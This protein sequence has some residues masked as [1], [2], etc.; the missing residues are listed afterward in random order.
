MEK[1]FSCEFNEISKKTF[2]TEHLQ[3]TVFV[4]ILIISYGTKFRPH[5]CNQ[6]FL[7]RK[8]FNISVHIQL[9]AGLKA[10][11]RKKQYFSK[12]RY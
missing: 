6:P 7:L 4:R 12:Y 11:S 1:V 8:A 2:F 10:V 5:F 9:P 3:T